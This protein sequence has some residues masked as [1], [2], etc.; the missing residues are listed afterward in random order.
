M[1]CPWRL[2]KRGAR[3]QDWPGLGW[4]ADDD[5]GYLWVMAEMW[6]ALKQETLP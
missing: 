2:H 6:Q 4:P 5:G 1:G 3:A